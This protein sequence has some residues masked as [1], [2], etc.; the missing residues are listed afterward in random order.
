[1]KT[2]PMIP[3]IHRPKVGFGLYLLVMVAAAFGATYNPAVNAKLILK[4]DG[5]ALGFMAAVAVQRSPIHHRRSHY[6]A[7]WVFFYYYLLFP[8]YLLTEKG[9]RGALQGLAILL[10]IVAASLTPAL[11]M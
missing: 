6:P 3:Y 8:L 10:L 1:M 9:W 4:L 2:S 5:I 7:D 11:L